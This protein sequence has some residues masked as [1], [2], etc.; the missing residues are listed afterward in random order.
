MIRNNVGEQN[1]KYETTKYALITLI[2]E[3]ARNSP[4]V[5]YNKIIENFDSFVR[6]VDCY[7]DP[8]AFI[9]EATGE[10]V[11]EFFNLLSNRDCK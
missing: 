7:K 8:R 5:V 4:V 6:I 9:R 3:Y 10:L 2:K 1:F 11:Q